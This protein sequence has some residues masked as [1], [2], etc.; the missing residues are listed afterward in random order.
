MRFEVQ[1]DNSGVK[2]R[3]MK[4]GYGNDNQLVRVVSGANDRLFRLQGRMVGEVRRG[5]Q[6]DFSLAADAVCL[7]GG[8]SVEDKRVIRAGEALEFLRPYGMKGLGALLTREQLIEAWEITAEEYEELLIQ[9]LPMVRLSNGV[10]HPECAVDEFFRHHGNPNRQQP[11][12]LVGT[13]YIA[14]R[15]GCT[16]TYVTQLVQKHEI[17]SNCIVPGTGNGKPWKFIRVRIDE[18]LKRR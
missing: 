16:A 5:L 15:L 10:R 2:G 4:A 13:R 18:W 11:P 9:G 8:V 17:P 12:D 7:I 14:D 6:Q 3:G 1:V